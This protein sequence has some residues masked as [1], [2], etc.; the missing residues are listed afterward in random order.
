MKAESST[1]RLIVVTGA[2]RSGTTAI[3]RMLSLGRGVGTLHEP[4]NYLV[5]MREIE[6]Y[7]EIPGSRLCSDEKFTG[8]MHRI[9][10][11]RIAFKPGIF[12]R[13]R[14]PR[15]T[16]KRLLGGRAINSYRLCRLTPGLHTLIWKDPFACFATNRIARD[17]AAH[18]VVTL[19]NPWAVAASFKRMDWGFDLDDLRERLLQTD[20]RCEYFAN[21]AWKLRRQPA[22]NAALLWHAIYSELENYGRNND[23]FHFI[24]LDDVLADPLLIYRKTYK[25]LQLEWT[26]KI[27]KTIRRQYTSPHSNATPRSQKAHDSQRDLTSINRYWKNLLTGEEEEVIQE[28]NGELWSTLSTQAGEAAGRGVR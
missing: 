20:T 4:F 21:P 13:E 12:P 24:N 22:I 18:I 5:G 1:P 26:G 15:K 10:S 8:C 25:S 2:P 19:R 9:R 27:E 3:G 14:E 28:L 11:L 7:F 6:R 17:Y 23:S 16:I